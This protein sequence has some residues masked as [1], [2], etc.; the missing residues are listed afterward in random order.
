[1]KIARETIAASILL[2]F[3][4]CLVWLP[5]GA[6]FSA[7]QMVGNAGVPAYHSQLPAGQLPVTLSPRQFT[8]PVVQNAYA[9]AGRMK[10]TLYQQPCYCYCGRSQG[11]GS[12]LD[13]FVSKHGSG[14]DICILEAFYSY[15][16]L[17]KGK[18]PAQI[19]AGIKRGDWQQVDTSKYGK[20]PV[21][22]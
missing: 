19:R 10:K 8:D 5:Q 15:E 7:P 12:L 21:T 6:G 9:I 17:R 4:A 3:A 11:H 18:T 16:Q 1:M 2:G 20:Y 22:K 14:C 13:C